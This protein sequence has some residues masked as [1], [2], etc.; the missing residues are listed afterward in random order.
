MRSPIDEICFTGTVYIIKFVTHSGETLYT[1]ILNFTVIWS[2]IARDIN[3]HPRSPIANG[4]RLPVRSP[5]LNAFAER[6]ARSIKEE[7]LDHLILFGE[8]SLQRTL[9]N[10]LEHYHHERPHREKDNVILFPR[11]SDSDPPRAGPVFCNRR[12][13]GL[14][15]FYYR[16]AA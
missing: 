13:G 1:K 6:F 3:V 7:C 14:L 15:K 8:A 4:E 9:D 2:V 10:Y 12:L 5:N 16:A 11:Q